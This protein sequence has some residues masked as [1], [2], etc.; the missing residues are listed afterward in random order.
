MDAMPLD[1]EAALQMLRWYP[2]E[3]WYRL[4][5]GQGL[6]RETMLAKARAQRA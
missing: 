3:H 6:D 5:F 2:E 1:E 4:G